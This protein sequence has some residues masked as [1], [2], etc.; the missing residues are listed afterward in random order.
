RSGD[1]LPLSIRGPE[2]AI[3]IEYRVPVPSAQVKSAILLAGL[4]APGTTTVIEPIMTRDHTERMLQAFG[5]VVEIDAAEDGAR[6]IRLE[7]RPRLKP[8]AITVPGDPSSAAFPLIAAILVEGSEVTVEGVLLNPTRIGFVETL[9]EM[10]ADITVQNR[11]TVGGETVGDLTARSSRLKGIRVPAARA[12]FMIDEYPVLSVAA[13]F[14]EGET[15]MEGVGELRVKESDRI[16]TMAA[17]LAANGVAVSHTAD[18]MTVTGQMQPPGGG[19]VASSLDHR[20]AMSF[21]VLGIAAATPVT[22]DDASAIAT[23]FPDFERL[24][25]GLGATFEERAP[26]A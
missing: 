16:A 1:R 4:N 3:P 23:S 11:R 2:L 15:V 26:A 25:T 14:A 17:G 18:T 9:T 24:M 21:A 7:G 10:G 8:Q 13:A 5:A 6:V 20:V 19:T 12:P 22:I